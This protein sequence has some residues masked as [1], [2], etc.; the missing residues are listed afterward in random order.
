MK[1]I[2]LDMN[3]YEDVI[4]NRNIEIENAIKKMRNKKEYFLFSPAHMEEL[5]VI[6]RTEEN[7]EKAFHYIHERIINISYISDNWECLPSSTSIIHK[8]EHPYECFKRVIDNYDTT[9]IAEKNEEFIF[10]VRDKASLEEY[11]NNTDLQGIQTFEDI[12]TEMRINKKKIGDVNPE[13]LFDLEEIIKAFNFLMSDF[14]DELNN[15]EK[16]KDIKDSHSKIEETIALLYNFLEKIG[17][18]AEGKTKYRSR[19]HDVSHGIYATSSDIF[20]IGDKKLYYKTKAIYS[21]LSI[22]TRVL[23]RTEFIEYINSELD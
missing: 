11:Y 12:Q 9:L 3:I 14:C 13:D 18:K 21:L 7:E 6:L 23:N 15:L 8:Q 5:A 22:P 4:Q 2:Y 1:K 10:S 16:W 20:V 19:M 17:Y